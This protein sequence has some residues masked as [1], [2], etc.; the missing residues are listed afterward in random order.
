M[1]I[2]EKIDNKEE[3]KTNEYNLLTFF[4]INLQLCVYILNIYKSTDVSCLFTFFVFVVAIASST[5]FWRRSSTLWIFRLFR[6][7]PTCSDMFRRI[8]G[9]VVYFQKSKSISNFSFFRQ[10]SFGRF[11][12]LLQKLHIIF[13]GQ[14]VSIKFWE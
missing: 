6:S 5:A 8:C 11:L 4:K 10:M 3:E 14:L 9:I 2:L 1:H 12:N 7:V 13:V